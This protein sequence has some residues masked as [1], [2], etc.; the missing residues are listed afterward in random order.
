MEEN[1]NKKEQ[2]KLSYEELSQRYG[3]L[4]YQHQ[5]LTEEYRK[6]VAALQSRDFDYTS[7]FLSMLFKVVEHP[8]MYSDDFIP[9]VTKHI[10]DALYS[11]DEFMTRGQSEEKTDE[12]E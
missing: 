4:S 12:T 1:T 7:F 6:A 5:R 11:F 3:E 8:E 2:K 10:E 9:W